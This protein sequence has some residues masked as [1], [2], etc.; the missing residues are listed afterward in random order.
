MYFIQNISFDTVDDAINYLFQ[1][2]V[3]GTNLIKDVNN[4]DVN[5]SLLCNCSVKCPD[6]CIHIKYQVEYTP[7]HYQFTCDCECNCS[8]CMADNG[9][10]CFVCFNQLCSR[11]YNNNNKICYP[12]LFKIKHFLPTI[13]YDDC[14]CRNIIDGAG[15]FIGE[16]YYLCFDLVCSNCFIFIDDLEDT[17]GEQGK[18]FCVKC[19]QTFVDIK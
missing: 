6:T 7:C 13:K 1:N 5:V 17:D 4:K 8:G 14:G 18:G 12:C 19:I 9:G 10:E 16:M 15:L 2:K 11:C 3:R